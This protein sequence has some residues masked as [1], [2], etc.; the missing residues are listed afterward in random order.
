M[1]S[2][3]RHNAILTD[4]VRERYATNIVAEPFLAFSTAARPLFDVYR[5]TEAPA[6]E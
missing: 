4:F 2:E 1:I 3:Q 6:A 5:F